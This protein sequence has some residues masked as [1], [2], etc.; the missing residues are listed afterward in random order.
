MVEASCEAVFEWLY[1]RAIYMRLCV[2]ACIWRRWWA[3]GIGGLGETNVCTCFGEAACDFVADAAGAAG[4]NHGA[5]VEAEHFEDAVFERRVWSADG[6][7]GCAIAIC[8]D[9]VAVGSGHGCDCVWESG[10]KQERDV[11]L[12]SKFGMLQWE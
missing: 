3:Y 11:A 7:F 4:D 1:Q 10:N 6:G 9:A 2:S 8:G 5:A 12:F